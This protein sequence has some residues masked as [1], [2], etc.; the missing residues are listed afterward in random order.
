M[1]KGWAPPEGA[2]GY[3]PVMGHP[4]CPWC[5]GHG[6]VSLNPHRY[7]V[8]VT[9]GGDQVRDKPLTRDDLIR[10]GIESMNE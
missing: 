1:I 10:L 2:T 4:D 6:H 3:L 5:Y 7:C 9:Q 8:C